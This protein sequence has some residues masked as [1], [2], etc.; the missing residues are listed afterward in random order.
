MNEKIFL[1]TENDEDLEIIKKTLKDGHVEIAQSSFDLRLEAKILSNNFPLILADYDLI[2][3][4]A[5]VLYE[6]QQNRSKACLIFYGENILPEEVS[7]ILQKG[8]Y[9]VIPR[10]LLAER[11]HDTIVAGLENRKAFIEILQMMDELKDVNIRL[12]TE[13]DTLR[14][15][16][17]ELDFINRL[18]SEF[19]YDLNWDRVLHRIIKAGLEQVLRYSLFGL[20]YRTGAQW[21]LAVHVMERLA[22]GEQALLKRDIFPR[23][24]SQGLENISEEKVVLQ[25][26]CPESC[27]NT[28]SSEILDRMFAY[29]L[30]LAGQKLG[31]FLITLKSNEP[32]SE[33][34]QG[35]VSTLASILSLSLKNAQEYHKLREAAVTD[36]LTGVYNRKGLSDFLEKE[37]QRAKRY[38]KALSFVM[39]DMDDFKSINDSMGHQ[40]GDYVLRELAGIFKGMVRQPDI[41][42]RYGGDEFVILLPETEFREAEILMRRILNKINGH[43]FEWGSDKIKTGMSYGI[44]NSQELQKDDPEDLLIKL[45]DSRLYTSK[46]S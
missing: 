40:A 34:D 19:S 18:S 23:L 36:S 4:K 44:S 6:I 45:A 11:I 33:D 24:K 30:S 29:P 26:A 31:L 21:T 8:V 14:K 16:N 15:R 5:D 17:Q 10:S 20:L 22:N 2:R 32:M 27:G 35:L 39:I 12:E 3:S 1:I 9:A 41:V 42:A 25:L 7:Q 46:N 28:L 38:E 13:K 43:I 37:F